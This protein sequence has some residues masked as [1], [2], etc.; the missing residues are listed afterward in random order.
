M[1]ITEKENL[2]FE[3]WKKKREGFVSDGIV[4]EGAYNS[5]KIKIVF[6]LK[7]VNDP[8][9]G[10]W[11]LREFVREGARRQTWDNIT[12]WVYGIKNLDREINW[13]E[14]SEISSDRKKDMLRSICAINLKKT[15]G[16]H[17]SNN[18]EL[19]HIAVEEDKYY[20]SEQLSLYDG[21]D[22]IICCGSI[23]EYIIHSI[24]IDFLRD[25]KWKM[26]SRGVWFHEYKN[27]KFIISFSHPEARIKSNLL[28]YGLI[29][30]VKE[31][32]AGND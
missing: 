6:I 17:T 21:A 30:A 32:L 13:S 20:L 1:S 2:L 3:R 31:I 23:T 29:D 27:G 14:L 4:D 12:R 5:S 16:G 24:N 22:I 8:D 18:D 19:W 28:Y 15:P 10:D 9:G 7:E 25:P 26:T 11:D